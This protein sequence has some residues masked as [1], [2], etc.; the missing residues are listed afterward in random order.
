MS[1]YLPFLGLTLAIELPIV[2]L[3]AARGGRMRSRSVC[4]G[5]LLNL[6]THPLAWLS[7]AGGFM[8]FAAVEGAVFA[9]ELVGYRSVT[10]LSWSRAELVTA[11]A[12]GLTASLSFSF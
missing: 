5:A 9:V 2:W 3:L 1:A 8:G 12:N 11:F 6:L 4:D 7:Y 10:R